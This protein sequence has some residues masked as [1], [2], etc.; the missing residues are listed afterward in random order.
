MCAHSEDQVIGRNCCQNYIALVRTY[1]KAARGC[2][3]PNKL[4]RD[5]NKLYEYV[6]W[7]DCRRCTSL[8]Y[9]RTHARTHR[10]R[11]EMR[12]FEN[13]YKAVVQTDHRYLL[14]AY[15]KSSS[16]AQEVYIF[17]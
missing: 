12:L 15:D 10:A 3:K 14:R 16:T 17:L 8:E 11:G 9:A 1:D 7:S 13:Y 4:A 2:D 5:K 6:P